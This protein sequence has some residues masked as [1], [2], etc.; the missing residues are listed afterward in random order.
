MLGSQGPQGETGSAGAVGPQGETGSAGAVGPQGET[1]SA[2]AVGPQGAAGPQGSAGTNGTNGTSGR[3]AS[4]TCA[5]GGT[6]SIG[7]TGPGGGKVFYLQTAT[8][9]APW[10]YLEA[11]PNTW[12]GGIADPQMKWCSNTSNFIPNLSTGDTTTV[13]SATAIGAG[14]ANTQKMLRGCTFGAAIMATSYNGGG[15]SDW[16]LPSKDELNQLFSQS[17]IVGGF[18]AYFYWSSSEFGANLAFLQLFTNGG[19]FIFNKDYSLCIRPVRAF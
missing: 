7:D 14:Y 9:A 5:Q 17:A 11:A 16:F 3:D 6:C 13:Q 12:S 15:K 18:L 1:G 8:A 4:L 2:G 10:R 19:Q